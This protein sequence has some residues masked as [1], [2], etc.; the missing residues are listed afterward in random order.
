MSVQPEI[1]ITITTGART[2]G[3]STPGTSAEAPVPM[4]LDQLGAA[5]SGTHTSDPGAPT[6]QDLDQLA[7]DVKPAKKSAAKKSSGNRGK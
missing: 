4:A 2:A 5:G 3:E 6:P 1:A 7:E